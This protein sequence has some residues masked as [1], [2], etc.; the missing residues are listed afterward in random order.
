V[1]EVCFAGRVVYIGYAKA[2]VAYETKY[3]VMKELDILGS[4]GAL[5]PNFEAVISLLQSGLYPVEETITRTV[6]LAEAGEA[7][8]AW[9]ADP[10]AYTKIHV[11]FD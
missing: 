5:R 9:D 4:R 2:P 8:R 6:P 11:A 10:S 3:F 7:L 1:D